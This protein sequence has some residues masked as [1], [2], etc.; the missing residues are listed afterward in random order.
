MKR[1]LQLLAGLTLVAGTAS[2][3]SGAES[4]PVPAGHG[5]HVGD[6][7]M[8]SLCRSEAVFGGARAR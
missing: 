3:H 1:A 6:P 8:C 5:G 7:R 4:H 2:A